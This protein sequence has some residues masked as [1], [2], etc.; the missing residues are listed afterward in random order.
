MQVVRL[1]ELKGWMRSYLLNRLEAN[2]LR[3][4][5]CFTEL[6]MFERFEKWVSETLTGDDIEHLAAVKLH[7]KPRDFNLWLLGVFS[8]GGTELPENFFYHFSK[9]Q[10][11]KVSE[12]LV[13]KLQAHD[14]LEQA[15]HSLRV[16]DEVDPRDMN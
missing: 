7:L 10:L 11:Q 8:D 16:K 15:L 3:M 1:Q 2:P 14:A 9:Y 12:E 5:G 6:A 4:D 13:T